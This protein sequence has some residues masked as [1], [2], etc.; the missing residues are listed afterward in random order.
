M[1]YCALSYSSLDNNKHP[2]DFSRLCMC[3]VK[4][5]KSARLRKECYWRAWKTGNCLAVTH[6]KVLHLTKE[7]KNSNPARKYLF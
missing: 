5:V 2:I 1:K 7:K 4:R 3:V 6:P